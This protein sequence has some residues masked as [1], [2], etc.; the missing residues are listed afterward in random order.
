M[1]DFPPE[2]SIDSPNAICSIRKGEIIPVV[3]PYHLKTSSL[4]AVW[5]AEVRRQPMNPL[6]TWGKDNK[7]GE[8]ILFPTS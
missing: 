4:H 3:E 6:F 1:H 7:M 5:H 8:T 2:S